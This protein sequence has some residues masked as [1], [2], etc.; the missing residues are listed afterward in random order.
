MLFLHPRLKRVGAVTFCFTLFLLTVAASG[1][2][3]DL[4]FVTTWKTD[5]PGSSN[6]TSISIPT[7]GDGYLYDVDWDNDGIYD[8]LGVTG[9]I[10]HDYGQ[11]GIRTIRIRGDFPQINF[12]EG[13][14][15]EKL[16]KILFW[17]SI[18]W[19][20]ME[21]AFNGCKNLLLLTIDA[22]DLSRVTS[23]RHMFRNCERLNS[24]VNH[25]DVRSVTDMSG[26]FK[27]ATSF[28]QALNQWD[29]SQVTNFSEMFMEAHSF[30]QHLKNWDVSSATDMSRMFAYASSFNQEIGPWKT[31]SVVTMA[32]MFRAARQFNQDLRKWKTSSVTD[33]SSMFEDASLFDREI[34]DWDVSNVVTMKR[35]FHSAKVFNRRIGDWDTREVT[36]MNDMFRYT[37]EFNQ[38]IGTWN[39]AKVTDI[40]G[41]FYSAKAFNQDISDWDVSNVQR[42]DGTFA[43]TTQFNQ[44]L[45]DWNV[46]SVTDMS[47]LFWGSVFNQDLRS[48][49]ITRVAD[50][51]DLFAK[52]QLSREN[53]DQL[54]LHWIQLDLQK[55]VR[56]DVGTSNYCEGAEAR[57]S[58]IKDYGWSITDGGSENLPPTAICRDVTVYL[59]ETGQ[60]T[61][62]AD[63]LDGGSFDGCN[64][65]MLTFD[66]SQ[67]SFNCEDI[68]TVDVVLTVK[69]SDGNTVTCQARVTVEDAPAGI[70]HMP[71]NITVAANTGDCEAVVTWIA[72]VTNCRSTLT[73]T[74]E[75]GDTFPLGPTVVSYMAKEGSGEPVVASFVVTVTSDLA[76]AAAETE[77]VSCR[78]ATD[79]RATLTLSG[80]LSPYQYDW[81]ADGAGEFTGRSVNSEL[82][83]GESQVKVIDAAGCTAEATVVVRAEPIKFTSEPE[84]LEILTNTEDCRAVVSWTN[85]TVSCAVGDLV[86]NYT[87]GDTFPVGSTRV[88]YTF[89]DG[90]GES[91]SGDFFVHVR[92]DLRLVIEEVLSPSCYNGEDGEVVVSA[93]GGQAPYLYDWNTDATGDFDDGPFPSG[94]RAGQYEVSVQDS[95]GCLASGTVKLND[96][97]ELQLAAEVLATENGRSVDLNI[98]GGTAPYQQQWSGTGIASHPEEEDIQVAANGTFTVEVTDDAGCIATTEV[99]VDGLSEA[100]TNMA[101]EVFPNPTTGVFSVKFERCAYPIPITVYDSYGRTIAVTNSEDLATDLDFNAL[102]RGLYFLRVDGR[103]EV[104]SRTVLVQ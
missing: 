20:S 53:Y 88:R 5:N 76:I 102:T 68:G 22:P 18:E 85:P 8:S 10:T 86:S 39:T 95:T 31:T 89:S 61:I 71:E 32:G 81:A 26:L 94:L 92:S 11:A 35:M 79:G 23:M 87:S 70:Y 44:D 91:I 99:A 19:R 3:Q 1:T 93:T 98:S 9:S 60:A 27:G 41:M 47:G 83:Y 15:A 59:D 96:P 17:G 54:L 77:P 101:F 78:S 74:Y 65:S 36:T 28:N 34:G 2:S 63:T 21:N 13:G 33:M 14:D 52:G 100:C 40:S 43:W 50:M 12:N 73:S 62:K 30:D 97:A 56:L 64:E 104:T 42:M 46:S 66:A 7:S 37:L 51:T 38:D 6:S 84:D 24:Y 72:P 90:E 16:I 29:V 45:S 82:P 69:D 67:T 75:S 48:W 80:G 57:A 103:Y 4:P 58:L 25:W 49:D 55:N